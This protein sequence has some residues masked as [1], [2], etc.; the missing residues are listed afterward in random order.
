MAFSLAGDAVMVYEEYIF[1]YGVIV[2]AFAQV[3][4]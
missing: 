1:L 3:V 4:W 2:F